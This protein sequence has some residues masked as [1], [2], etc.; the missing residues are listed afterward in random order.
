MTSKHI[1]ETKYFKTEILIKKENQD[2]K[3]VVP[4]YDNNN[5]K[6]V[7]NVENNS[8]LET[9]EKVFQSEDNKSLDSKINLKSIDIKLEDNDIKHEVND[10][11]ISDNSY[12]ELNEIKPK[13]ESLINEAFKCTYK[14]CSRSFKSLIAL[15][16]H[17][18]S[19][20]KKKRNVNK[21][22]LSDNSDQESNE[23]RTKTS[24]NESFIC[25]FDDCGSAFTSH[26]GLR[27]HHGKVHQKKIDP[28]SNN[29]SD[30]VYGL[31]F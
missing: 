28:S 22:L 17:H 15:R 24:T 9:N 13:T 21:Q 3:E 5:N 25:T 30:K 8:N 1:I 12:Q 18:L 2:N 20:H 4:N 31:C 11:Q 16:A 19:A 14:E 7:L 26:K 10:Q 27:F 23:S 6:N 29:G